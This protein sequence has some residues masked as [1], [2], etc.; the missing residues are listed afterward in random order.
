M[1]A[2]TITPLTVGAK[3]AIRYVPPSL[4]SEARLTPLPNFQFPAKSVHAIKFDKKRSVFKTWTKD[5]ANSLAMTL[6]ADLGYWRAGRVVKDA[7]DL[8]AV[9]RVLEK[10]FASIKHIYIELITR[11]D[12]YPTVGSGEFLGF[13]RDNA[14]M[15]EDRLTQA[16]IEVCWAGTF[17]GKRAVGNECTTLWRHEFLEVLVRMAVSKYAISGS[18]VTAAQAVELLIEDLLSKYV[19]QPWQEFRDQQLWTHAVDCL[20]KVN[21]DSLALVYREMF[22]KTIKDHPIDTF[23]DLLHNKAALGI[24]KQEVQFCFGMSKMTVKDEIEQRQEYERLKNS[25]FLEFL[26]RLAH[27]KYV[28][29]DSRLDDKLYR[30]M[31][32]I[33]K[34]FG[35]RVK[36]PEEAE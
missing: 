13:C 2:H 28:D 22:P 9:G 19:P 5:T 14:I 25:E 27:A 8:A 15:D 20:F 26:S 17:S 18:G 23:T 35:I 33:L 21:S 12:N 10:R 3:L 32:A 6:K 4:V 36:S 31:R 1:T 7:N 29:E 24:S 16:Q 11:G 34:V 30:I